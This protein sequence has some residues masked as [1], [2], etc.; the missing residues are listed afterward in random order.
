MSAADSFKWLVKI[1]HTAQ[2][3]ILNLNPFSSQNNTKGLRNILD[4]VLLRAL[5][6]RRT[7]RVQVESSGG[8]KEISRL[9]RDVTK[10]TDLKP[11][12]EIPASQCHVSGYHTILVS[13]LV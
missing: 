5:I 1:N 7:D 12:N 11:K 10:I 8:E 9:E 3:Q 13:S 4:R 6:L 2:C